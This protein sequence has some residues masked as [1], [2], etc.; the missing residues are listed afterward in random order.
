MK[1]GIR[2]LLFVVLLTAIPLGAY[3]WVFRPT[4]QHIEQQRRD[5]EANAQ[6]L[7]RLRQA[8]AGAA[9]LNS[10]VQ[11]LQ[12]AVVFFESKLP[13]QHEIHKVLEQVSKIA[14]S[15]KLETKLFETQK[16]KPFAAYSEQPIKMEVYG[17]FDAFYQFLLDV[18]KLPRIT[19]IKEMK[20]EKD[21]KADGV[22]Q[23]SLMLSIFFDNTHVKAG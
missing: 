2:E 8:M 15:H 9:D 5:V 7:A 19:K 12:D 13:A 21:K 1:F 20:L 4:N 23:A 11:K 17:D 3:F 6:K 10:E 14:E 18:E 16:P 22:M